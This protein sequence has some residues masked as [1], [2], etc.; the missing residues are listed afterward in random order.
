MAAEDAAVLS[1]PDSADSGQAAGH[2]FFG[3]FSPGTGPG[4]WSVR[5]RAGPVDT[6][7][8]AE[9]PAASRGAAVIRRVFNNW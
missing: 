4:C 9:R 2:L 3:D 1:L 7:T 8:A 5:D 6:Q